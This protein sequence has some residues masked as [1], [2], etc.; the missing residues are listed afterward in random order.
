M[1]ETFTATLQQSPAPGGWTCVVWP[2]SAGRFGTRGLVGVHLLEQ[3][4]RRG[5]ASAS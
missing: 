5:A 1:D 2:G 4:A 3:V